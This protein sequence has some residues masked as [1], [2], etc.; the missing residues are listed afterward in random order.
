MA[1]GM[2]DLSFDRDRANSRSISAKI[3]S[4]CRSGGTSMD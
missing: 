3:L 1:S 4:A 2:A